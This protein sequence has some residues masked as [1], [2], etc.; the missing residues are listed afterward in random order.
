MSILEPIIE[1]NAIEVDWTLVHF[2]NLE[3]EQNPLAIEEQLG[4]EALA[5]VSIPIS[6]VETNELIVDQTIV[7]ESPMVDTKNL[8]RETNPLDPDPFA[9]IDVWSSDSM[10][11]KLLNLVTTSHSHIL[12]KLWLSFED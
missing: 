8:Q 12:M 9:L 2:S 5:D 11:L 1:E 4:F 6:V 10:S 3:N 7:E